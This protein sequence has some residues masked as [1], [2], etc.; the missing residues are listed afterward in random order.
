MCLRHI[1]E[2]FKHFPISPPEDDWEDRNLLYSLISNLCSSTLFPQTDKFRKQAVQTMSQLVE[3][4]PNG[5]EGEAERKNSE[6]LNKDAVHDIDVSF[7]KADAG[8]EQAQQIQDDVPQNLG[9]PMQSNDESKHTDADSGFA[10]QIQDDT[11][12]TRD[13]SV[14]INDG[15][16]H[17]D[18]GSDHTQQSQDA[19][20]HTRAGI[21]QSLDGSNTL[22]SMAS[23]TPDNLSTTG[24]DEKDT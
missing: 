1:R 16:K 17:T 12:H 23:Q 8:S 7:H 6:Q 4:Y 10:Q 19:T 2:Y 24:D 3:K 5:Y 22:E 9:K 13:E 21:V 18:A 11:P 15:L 20:P 14:Q